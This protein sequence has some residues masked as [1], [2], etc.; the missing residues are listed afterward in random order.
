ML[1]TVAQLCRVLETYFE[2]APINTAL[3]CARLAGQI[4]AGSAGRDGC[5]SAPVTVKQALLVALAL[6][7]DQHPTHAAAD[8]EGIAAFRLLR[9]DETHSRG[10]PP[11]PPF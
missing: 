1:T 2:P 3:R 9:D 7:R 4:P 10:E 11:R 6:A 5:G 8:P